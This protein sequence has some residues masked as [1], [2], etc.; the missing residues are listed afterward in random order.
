MFCKPF[1]LVLLIRG[2]V[3]RELRE[4]VQDPKGPE[5]RPR[6]ISAST[7]ATGHF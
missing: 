3:E 7:E 6:D 1:E 4:L 2:G 5:S